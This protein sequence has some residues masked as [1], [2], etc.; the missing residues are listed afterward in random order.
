MEI[1][2]PVPN[3]NGLASI[4]GQLCTAGVS[5]QSDRSLVQVAVVLSSN[6]QSATIDDQDVLCLEVQTI[7]IPVIDKLSS[8]YK[9]HLEDGRGGVQHDGLSGGDVDQLSCQRSTGA[10]PC[11]DGVPPVNVVEVGC[12]VS[13]VL[14][15]ALSR[16]LHG[17]WHLDTARMAVCQA[18]DGGGRL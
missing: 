3:S 14:A 7:S 12:A 18:S 9:Q 15:I 6:L 1:K 10:A 8:I 4:D 16:N 2:C 11:E 13:R 5:M 17:D